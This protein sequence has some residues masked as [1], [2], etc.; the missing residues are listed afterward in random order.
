MTSS[1]G[2]GLPT[3]EA[4][5]GR[6]PDSLCFNVITGG[7]CRV[8]VP[9]G[10]VTVQVLREKRSQTSMPAPHPPGGYAVG[11]LGKNTRIGCQPPSEL[12][13]LIDAAIKFGTLPNRFEEM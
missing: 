9:L 10:S 4:N 5:R 11:M 8:A 2:K 6:Y 7:P 3:A 1:T 12:V 13:A